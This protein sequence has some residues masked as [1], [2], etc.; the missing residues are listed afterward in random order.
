MSEWFWVI[1]GYGTAYVALA[2]YLFRNRR[3]EADLR[4]RTERLP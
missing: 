2:G 4:R 3:R 1:L